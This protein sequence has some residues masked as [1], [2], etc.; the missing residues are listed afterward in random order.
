MLLNMA[1]NHPRVLR[2]SHGESRELVATSRGKLASLDPVL[3]AIRPVRDRELAHLDRK[4]L[5]DPTAVTP[6]A[7]R[8]QDLSHC[9]D[10][11]NMILSDIWLALFGEPLPE[12]QETGQILKEM[13]TLWKILE[14]DTEKAGQSE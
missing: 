10:I 3:K 2:H 11:L 14:K 9:V 13:E 7:I 5:N 8:L 1:E 4:Q 6:K 12:D